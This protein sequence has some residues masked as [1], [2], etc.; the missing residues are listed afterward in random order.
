MPHINHMTTSDVTKGF[1]PKIAQPTP[2]T[3][4][5]AFA[6][7]TADDGP[8]INPPPTQPKATATKVDQVLLKKLQRR[9]KIQQHWKDNLRRLR[10]SDKLFLDTCITQAKDEQTTMAKENTT[11]AKR[12]AIN[13]EHRIEKHTIGLLQQGQNIAYRIGSA[14]N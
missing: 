7:L 3:T 10:N 9:A 14:F 12:I 8:E 6:I 11:N 1:Q 2:T 5:N 13:K 4:H